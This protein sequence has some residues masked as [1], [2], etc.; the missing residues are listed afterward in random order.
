MSERPI[1]WSVS[2][3]CFCRPCGASWMSWVE[4]PTPQP[5]PQWFFC[6]TCGDYAEHEHIQTSLDDDSDDTLDTPDPADWWKR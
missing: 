1:P 2:Y 6:P 4:R 5:G 3:L